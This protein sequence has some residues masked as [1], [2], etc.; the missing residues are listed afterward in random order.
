MAAKVRC[1]I[2]ARY[3]PRPGEPEDI[4]S[5]KVQIQ[6]CREYAAAHGY[7]V[8]EKLIFADEALSGLDDEQDPD[9]VKSILKRPGIIAAIE[10][11]KKGMVLLVRWRNRIA[12]DAYVQGWARRK[13]MKQGGRIEATDEANIEG[14]A[15]E[16]L[17]NTLATV[18]K[19]KAIQIGIDT[20]LA[21]QKYQ[22]SGRRMTRADQCPFGFAVDPADS[23]RMIED[24]V[25]HRTVLLILRRHALGE[26]PGAICK[27]LDMMVGHK[28]RGKSWK[29][30]RGLVRTII[31][32]FGDANNE[33]PSQDGT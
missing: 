8:N 15:G 16:L 11:T 10:A 30:G 5:N 32:R 28:R 23:T 9:P 33:P 20:A 2:Y 22:K 18:D 24:P 6:R 4:H 21:M 26:K 12:R 19:Y 17:E 1:C 27:Y 13:M 29:G 14:L 7:E 25:E 31:S 3:S